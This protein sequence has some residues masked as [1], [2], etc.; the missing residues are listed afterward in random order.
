VALLFDGART[1]WLA[2]VGDSRAYRVRGASIAQ[3]TEDDS[4]VAEQ[5]RKGLITPEEAAQRPRNEL[6]RAVGMG[7]PLAI[8]VAEL[9]VAEGDR[10]VLCSDGLWNVVEDGEI[11][12]AVMRESPEAVVKGL[13]ALAN[14]RGARDNVTVGVISAGEARLAEAAGQSAPPI[15]AAVA[16]SRADRWIRLAGLAAL[17]VALALVGM[18]IWMHRSAQPNGVPSV[19]APDPGAAP[20]LDPAKEPGGT[21]Q[22]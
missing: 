18:L 15:R 11:A 10:F 12:E 4:V 13:V 3:L 21:T 19:S 6:T 1:A 7:V 22:R 9:E 20:Q 8:S 17:G 2:H 14:Q 5:L 16:R